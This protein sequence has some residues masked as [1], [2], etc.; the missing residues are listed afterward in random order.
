MYFL[1]EHELIRYI[2]IMYV[3]KGNDR[4]DLCLKCCVIK[5]NTSRNKFMLYIESVKL[6]LIRLPDLATNCL[7]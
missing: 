2:I 7:I 5:E 1:P 6:F 4:N 3:D